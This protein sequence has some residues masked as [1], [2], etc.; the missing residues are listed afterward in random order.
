VVI[1]IKKTVQEKTVQQDDIVHIGPR[2]AAKSVT[3]NSASH[4]PGITLKAA[5]ED[6]A[7]MQRWKRKDVQATVLQ[8]RKI[9]E[10]ILTQCRQEKKLSF[11]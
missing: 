7:M 2:A 11:T 3:T 8:K 9:L 5:R 1:R 6:C 10:K 4:D